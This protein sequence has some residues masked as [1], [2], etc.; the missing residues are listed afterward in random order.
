[1]K[2]AVVI[3]V[4]ADM[5][6]G[7][8]LCRRFA[9]LGLEVYI[10]GRT[11]KAIDKIATDIKK[12]G[13]KAVAV[14]TDA[15]DE[16]SVSQLFKEIGSDLDLAI[17]NVGNNTPGKIIEMSCDYF[18]QSWRVCCLAGFI[19]GKEALKYFVPQKKGTILFTGA[20]ASWRGKAGFGAFNSAKGGLRQLAQAM[21]KEYGPIG[22]HVGHIVVDGIINGQM[23]RNRRPE[24]V[25]MVGE[26]KLI[27]I[28]SIVDGYVFMYNQSKTGW[29]FELDVRNNSENW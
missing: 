3:G 23:I 7:G 18:E 27:D 14:P 24:I 16:N 9:K 28:Q 5:G 19:F 4:H 1:M 26:E 25:K 11:K 13:G 21:A 2:K 20:S 22:I 17:Y 10:A 12:G 8:Q 15:T 6:L 29:T